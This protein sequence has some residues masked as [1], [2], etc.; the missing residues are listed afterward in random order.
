MDA[1]IVRDKTEWQKEYIETNMGGSAS[2]GIRLRKMVAG[3]R[4]RLVITGVS[5][6]YWL[7]REFMFLTRLISIM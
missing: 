6:P 1:T 7:I 3:I 4:Q 5:I 2:Q